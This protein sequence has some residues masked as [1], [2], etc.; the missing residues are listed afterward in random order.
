VTISFDRPIM[1]ESKRINNVEKSGEVVFYLD[2]S[3]DAPEN[4]LKPPRKARRRKVI[5]AA[6]ASETRT[7][8]SAE[9]RTVGM[10]ANEMRCHLG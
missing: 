2:Q 8:K 9:A 7:E 5:E 1:S 4:A 3:S 10:D 6:E